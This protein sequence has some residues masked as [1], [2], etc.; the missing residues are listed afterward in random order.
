M[1]ER[2]QTA[3]LFTINNDAYY[4]NDRVK[5]IR[6]TNPNKCVLFCFNNRTGFSFFIF[7]E[8][9]S[10]HIHLL[11]YLVQVFVILTLYSEEHVE[12]NSKTTTIKS[13]INNNFYSLLI[14]IDLKI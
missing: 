5:E 7:F 2:A 3:L 4:L 6:N 14:L 9:V 10:R 11:S 13:S 8:E 1:A 12:M